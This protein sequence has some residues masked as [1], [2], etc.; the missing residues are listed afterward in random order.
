MD[1]HAIERVQASWEV[2][3]PIAD[4]AATLFYNR[5][6]ELDPALRGMFSDDLTEQKAKLMQMITVAVRGLDNLDTLVPAVQA[7]GRRH[8]GYG[9]TDAHYD[10]VGAA[11]LWT[12]ATGL[13]DA[14]SDQLQEDWTTVYGLLATTMK[15]AAKAPSPA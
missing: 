13:G 11:L 12:L 7:L 4:T 10:T 6:F 5:L 8:G 2:V 14:W 9:V 15:D 3:V 1:S